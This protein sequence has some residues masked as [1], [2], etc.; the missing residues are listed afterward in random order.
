M[1]RTALAVPD[2]DGMTFRVS[3]AAGSRYERGL[4]AF[5]QYRD[6]GIAAATGGA[7]DARIVKAVPGHAERAPWHAHEL[8]FQLVFVLRGSIT[9][10]YAGVGR[11]TLEPGDCLHPPPGIHHVEI[12]HSDDYEGLEITIPAEFRTVE[13]AP[14]APQPDAA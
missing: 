11:V 10:E 7:V 13:V 9:L 1:D 3:R 12:T 2:A 5:M 8:R 4:R 14:P 6:L